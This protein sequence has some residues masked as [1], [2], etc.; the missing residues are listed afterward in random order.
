MPIY[1]FTC[2]SCGHR[3]ER[4]QSM[5]AADP[6]TCPACSE[7]KV[8]RLMSLSSFQLKGSGWYVTDY[9]GKNPASFGGKSDVSG[10]TSGGTESSKRA[11]TQRK[12]PR[13]AA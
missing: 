3:F 1:E 5:S 9:K 6:D 10:G 4:I 11:V 12:V 2:E 8:R 7:Q 13:A